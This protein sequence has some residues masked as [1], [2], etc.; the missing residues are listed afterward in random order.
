MGFCQRQ[1]PGSPNGELHELLAP[2][3]PL[4]ERVEGTGNHMPLACVGP[5]FAY[6]RQTPG[7]MNALPSRTHS[8]RQSQETA[9]YVLLDVMVSL[10]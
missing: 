4:A 8:V 3:A 5:A 6:L 10:T 7:K 9:A 1:R 2:S